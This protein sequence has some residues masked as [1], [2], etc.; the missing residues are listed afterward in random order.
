VG[1]TSGIWLPSQYKG[2]RRAVIR[3]SQLASDGVVKASEEKQ[4]E[5]DWIDFLSQRPTRI[6]DLTVW[7]RVKQQVVDA[8]TGQSQLEKLN[9]KWGNYSDLTA[10]GLLSKLTE[11]E[12]GGARKVADL[13]PLGGLTSLR[14]LVVSEAHVSDLSPIGNLTRLTSLTFGNAYLGSDK[15]IRILNLDWI[16]PL[17]NLQHLW[18]PGTNLAG[19]DLA[20][21]AELPKLKTL[22]IPTRARHRAQIFALAGTSKPFRELVKTYEWLDAQK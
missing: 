7:S 16:E 1:V 14:K 6:K 22:S 15:T 4:I 20:V 9:L 10:I 12:L 21:F 5:A 11:L 8:L 17:V 3:V 18:L 13:K 2:A 19:L